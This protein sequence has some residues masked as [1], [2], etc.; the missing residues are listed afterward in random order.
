MVQNPIIKEKVCLIYYKRQDFSSLL[1]LYYKLSIFAQS[2]R[3]KRFYHRL[4]SYAS[5]SDT[6]K[7]FFMFPLSL[8][9]FPFSKIREMIY[10]HR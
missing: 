2:M 6:G 1:L 5:N 10:Y 4:P 3:L 7:E 9:W 8:I